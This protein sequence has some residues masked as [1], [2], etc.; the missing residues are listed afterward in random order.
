MSDCAKVD[1]VTAGVEGKVVLSISGTEGGGL[2]VGGM[3]VHDATPN[4]PQKQM[5]VI[6]IK[7]RIDSVILISYQLSV[8]SVVSEYY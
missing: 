3:K 8:F 7:R 5:R 6:F 4:V 2:W 1:C